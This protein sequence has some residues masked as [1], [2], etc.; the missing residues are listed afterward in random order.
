MRLSVYIVKLTAN[1]ELVFD[2]IAGL[3]Q[4]SLLKIGASLLDL[5]KSIPYELKRAQC[6]EE[7]IVNASFLCR[8]LPRR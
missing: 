7:N 4:V 8:F 5:V 1:Q 3:N 2:W 6:N